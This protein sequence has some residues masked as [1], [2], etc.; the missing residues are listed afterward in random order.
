MANCAHAATQSATIA[1]DRATPEDRATEALGMPEAFADAGHG[2]GE[3]LSASRAP[4]APLLDDQA[5]LFAAKGRV[6][7]DDA[8]SVVAGR[9]ERG[10]PWTYLRQSRLTG[11]HEDLPTGC[12][13]EGNERKFR[14][15][16][17]AYKT[18]FGHGL[19]LRVGVGLDTQ[20]RR[21]NDPAM[22]NFQRALPTLN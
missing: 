21:R 7:D 5:D 10:A 19:A 1:P 13:A 4:K 15:E 8:A 14:K 9:A 2:L 16:Q 3:R 17:S 11:G 22:P 20:T 12:L 18:V 6:L